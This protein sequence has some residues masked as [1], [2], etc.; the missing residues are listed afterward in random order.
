[1]KIDLWKLFR[2]YKVLFSITCTMYIRCRFSFHVI[3]YVTV[4]FFT[5][6][7]S[8]LPQNFSKKGT[9]NLLVVIIKYVAFSYVGSSY[10]VSLGWGGKTNYI[11]STRVSKKLVKEIIIDLQCMV[12]K[13][14]RVF[15]FVR[16]VSSTLGTQ[17]RTL[18]CYVLDEVRWW[19][20]MNDDVL[21]TTELCHRFSCEF[22]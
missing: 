11:W 9:F 22:E 15:A 8:V 18:H 20:M 19:T 3:F 6:S 21:D 13:F 4:N 12:L 17:I 16:R 7:N 14:F 10:L 5:G 2:L 1:M